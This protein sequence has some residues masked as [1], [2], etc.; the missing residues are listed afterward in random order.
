[1]SHC[2]TN[3]IVVKDQT[4]TTKAKLGVSIL[5][6][7]FYPETIDIS[8]GDTLYWVNNDTVTH[9]VTEDSSLF[10]SGD[11][12][13]GQE[14]HYTF[15]NEGSFYY[16]CSKTGKTGQINVG[17]GGEPEG[18]WEVVKK[19]ENYYFN[20]IYFSDVNNGWVIGYSGF[21]PNCNTKS[22]ILHTTDG[23][24]TWSEVNT[25][26]I[27]S[28]MPVDICFIDNKHGWLTTGVSGCLPGV[29]ASATSKSDAT[30]RIYFFY[31]SDGGNTWTGINNV[32]FSK[33]YFIDSKNGW[34]IVGNY[35]G[36]PNTQEIQNT[37]DGGYTWNTQYQGSN[38]SDIYFID[39][40]HIWCIGGEHRPDQSAIPIILNTINGGISWNKQNTDLLSDIPSIIFFSGSRNGWIV[41]NHFNNNNFPD[42]TATILH[43]T[44]GGASWEAQSN[45][46]LE[47]A[48]MYFINNSSGWISGYN[49]NGNNYGGKILYTSDYGKTW[50]PQSIPNYDHIDNSSIK[51]L[52]FPDAHNGWAIGNWSILKYSVYTPTPIPTIIPTIV[53][54]TTSATP[55]PNLTSTPTT[56]PTVISGPTSTPTVGL[57]IIFE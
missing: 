33:I 55:T 29:I 43:T 56:M 26:Y 6:S 38:L 25:Y 18:K 30:S 13:P 16:H 5:D 45:V 12:A 54:T 52:C 50:N 32:G 14:F 51:S 10:N 44:N 4:V 23:G 53:P 17:Q 9:T 36:I 41:V 57:P 31:T 40:K 46:N 49:N 47:V 48:S 8:P 15:N 28:K 7:G 37:N 11:M 34:G 27:D 35:L 42:Y 39:S 3:I 20:K 22:V 1:M 24:N 2:K 21:D 19:F